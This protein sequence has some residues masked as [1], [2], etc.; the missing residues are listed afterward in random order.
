[1]A[2]ITLSISPELDSALAMAAMAQDVPKSRLVETML[3][4]HPVIRG[5]IEAIRAEPKTTGYAAS[6]R[7]AARRKVR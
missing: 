2:R 5:F 3:R 4:E 6:S 7:A 1:M